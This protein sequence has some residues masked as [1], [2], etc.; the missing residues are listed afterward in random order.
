[1]GTG[2]EWVSARCMGNLYEARGLSVRV[3]GRGT[4][5][6]MRQEEVAMVPG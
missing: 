3:G 4:A 6:G 1:M 5:A 2:C